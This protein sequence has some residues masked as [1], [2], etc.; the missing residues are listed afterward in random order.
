M[1]TGETARSVLSDR[2]SGAASRSSGADN[3]GTGDWSMSA[4]MRVGLLR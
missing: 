3:S 4:M 1:C 2:S